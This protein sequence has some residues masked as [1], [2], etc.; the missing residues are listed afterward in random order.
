M[1]RLYALWTYRVIVYAFDSYF[2]TEFRSLRFCRVYTPLSDEGMNKKIN[3]LHQML[4]IESF[5]RPDTCCY[6]CLCW[7][8]LDAI[9]QRKELLEREAFMLSSFPACELSGF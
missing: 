5:F 7:E 9:H 3:F 4:C 6:R 2:S 8:L 1:F